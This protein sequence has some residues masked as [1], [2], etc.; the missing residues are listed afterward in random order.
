MQQRLLLCL[1]LLSAP[2]ECLAG[3]EDEDLTYTK[4]YSIILKG[5]VSGTEKV[6]E[7]VSPDGKVLVNSTHEILVSD[8]VETKRMAFTT[9]MSL[10]KG[11]WL[12][13]HYSCRYSSGEARD[14]Y[15]VTVRDAQVVRTLTR[16]GRTSETK[17]Q[18]QPGFVIV[19]FNVYYQYDYLLHRYD[20]KKGGKQSF[21]NFIPLIAAGIRVALTRLEDS[22]FGTGD[23]ALEIRNFRVEFGSSWVGIARCDKN[24]RLVHLLLQDKELE[25]VRKDLLPE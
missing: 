15:E 4:E 1:F 24:G 3:A 23:K 14:S 7:R 2:N 20:L 11:T 12:P 17:I 19:D 6:T 22:T 13:I 8:G 10:Q 9:S 5:E 18:L 21:M 25:V 16:S